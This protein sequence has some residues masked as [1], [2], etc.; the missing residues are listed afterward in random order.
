MVNSTPLGE[1]IR[2]ERK[3]LRLTLDE[4]AERIGASKSYVWELEN[5]P[6]VRPSAEKIA[7]LAAVF[8]LPVEFLMDD[9]RKESRPSDL[10]EA[11]F[12]RVSRLSE[13]KREALEHFLDAIDRKP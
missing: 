13:E 12:H 2:T 8:K 10:Q 9:N 1:K 4:L 6:V 7:A 11:F 3:K 5:R